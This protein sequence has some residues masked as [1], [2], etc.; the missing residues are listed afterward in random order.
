MA[1]FVGSEK[2][3]AAIREI[4][5]AWEAAMRAQDV[6]ALSSLVTSD[7]VFHGPG[8]EPIRGRLALEE[9]LADVFASFSVEPELKLEE[10]VVSGDMAFFRAIDDAV[11]IPHASGDRLLASGWG[12]TI[13]TRDDEGAWRFSRGMNT[14]VRV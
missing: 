2:D 9:M 12:M 10:I 8:Q 6:R 3:I 7:C 5:D 11:A 14:R 13:L 4:V 1:H